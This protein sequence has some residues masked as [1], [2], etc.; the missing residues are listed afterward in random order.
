MVAR[1]SVLQNRTTET[2]AL[3]IVLFCHHKLETGLQSAAWVK[4]SGRR[5]PNE[6]LWW[7]YDFTCDDQEQDDG[8]DERD[9]FM[10]HKLPQEPV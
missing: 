3:Y 6:Q 7:G 5:M 2:G 8:G 4:R 9:L 1:T 10:G